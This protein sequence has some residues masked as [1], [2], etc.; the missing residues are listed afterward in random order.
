MKF[1]TDKGD[2]TIE[3]EGFE[4]L[5]AL[6]RKLV[7]PRRAITSLAWQAHFNYEGQRFFRAGGTGAPGLLFAGNFWSSSGWYFLYVRRP[8]G[9]HWLTGGGFTA[10]NILNITTEGYTYKRLML[11]C[12]PDVSTSL[13]KWWRG[14]ANSG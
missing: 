10:P 3:L 4:R 12:E 7:I 9:A 13:I 6:R 11:T 2:L 1:I 8:K 14:T 5:W